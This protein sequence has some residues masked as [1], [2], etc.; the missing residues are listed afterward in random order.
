MLETF[1]ANVLKELRSPHAVR[2]LF[3]FIFSPELKISIPKDN[4]I[5][6]HLRVSNNLVFYNLSARTRSSY[7]FVT[8]RVWIFLVYASGDIKWWARNKSCSIDL[9]DIAP[10]LLPNF[11]FLNQIKLNVFQKK[12]E[13]KA[14]ELMEKRDYFPQRSFRWTGPFPWNGLEHSLIFFTIYGYIKKSQRDQISVGLIAQSLSV[15]RAL[16]QLNYTSSVSTLQII[17]SKPRMSYHFF[18]E[19]FGMWC[20]WYFI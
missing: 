15:C 18:E 6:S 13:I 3:D 1:R 7:H 8:E 4:L 16:H 10:L 11:L 2:F 20:L 5:F 19:D 17:S 9:E 14:S 12:M